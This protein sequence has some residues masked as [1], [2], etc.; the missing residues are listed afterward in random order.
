VCTGASTSVDRGP[1][2]APSLPSGLARRSVKPVHV[3]TSRKK[4][5][6]VGLGHRAGVFVDAIVGKYSDR[7]ELVGLCDTNRTRMNYYNRRFHKEFGA[8][9][10]TTY[11]ADRFDSMV[12]EQRPDV[13]FV[14]TIDRTHHEYIIRAMELGCDVITEKPMTI[15]AEKCRAIFDAIQRTGRKLR[16]AF[17]YRYAPARTT[18]KDL[19]MKGTIGVVKAV[20]FEWLLDTRHGADYFRRWHRDK[21]NSGGLMVHKATHHFDLVNWWLDSSP[22]TVFGLGALAFYGRANAEARGDYRAYQRSTGSP[23]AEGDPF[24]LDLRKDDRLRALYLDAEHEDG[25]FRDQNV[26]GDG[27]TTEDTMNVL[28]RYRSGA[29]MSYSLTAYCPWEGCRVA[30]TGARGRIEFEDVETIEGGQTSTIV[31]ESGTPGQR[32]IVFPHWKKPYHAEIPPAV[33]G[34]GG[35]DV[36][37]AEAL[38]GNPPPDPYHRAASHIDGA[39]SILTGIAANIS[40]ATGA[41]VEVDRLFAL[42]DPAPSS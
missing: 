4:Y 28:V 34:H 37:L 41:P 32:I 10:V 30:F 14:T 12:R 7:S 13:V 1:D 6:F 3:N 19:L 40:F 2:A 42:P 39:R 21:R 31:G 17:N 16:V 20:H 5:A 24:A 15:D 26:F 27:I 22:Q 18:V 36:V 9:P 11:L 29:Q 33:G 8:R 38:F 35:G 25:Y 23:Q